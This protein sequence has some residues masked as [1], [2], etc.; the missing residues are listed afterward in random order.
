MHPFLKP[1]TLQ[2]LNE[3]IVLPSE[4]AYLSP[5]DSALSFLGCHWQEFFTESNAV[6]DAARGFVRCDRNHFTFD[7]YPTG[8]EGLN[9]CFND[10]YPD[11]VVK[12]GTRSI[13]FG[14]R[15]TA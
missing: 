11:Q 1:V 3:K 9:S 10:R 7:F 14:N 5:D 4:I 6:P 15:V 8:T 12:T 13:V 2:F